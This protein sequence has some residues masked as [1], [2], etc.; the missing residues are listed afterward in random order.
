MWP[1]LLGEG[2]KQL[3]FEIYKLNLPN[4]TLIEKIPI[5]LRNSKFK[6]DQFDMCF[7]IKSNKVE[8]L[9]FFNDFST[10]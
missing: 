1:T 2:F 3:K 5:D 8:I 6:L 4:P 9:A 10:L 7:T